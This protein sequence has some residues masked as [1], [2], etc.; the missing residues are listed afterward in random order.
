MS[1]DP[2]GW[3]LCGSVYYSTGSR[4]SIRCEAD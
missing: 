3:G 2:V 4:M 1:S